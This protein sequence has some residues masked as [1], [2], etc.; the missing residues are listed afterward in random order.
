MIMLIA[1]ICLLIVCLITGTFYSIYTY[2][3]DVKNI[4]VKLSAILSCAV[5]AIVTANLT[6][7]VGG[8]SIFAVIGFMFLLCA[9]CIS[10]LNLKENTGYYYLKNITLSLG[11]V[12]FYIAGL[13]FGIFNAFTLLFGIFVAI[14]LN[15]LNLAFK[16]H[17]KT[18]HQLIAQGVLL[19]SI[20]LFLSQGITLVLSSTYLLIGLFY[21][22][23]SIFSIIGLNIH[24][25]RKKENNLLRIA[26]NIV[27]ILGLITF[28]SSIYFI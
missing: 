16:R 9:E 18:K 23:G 21:L 6:S 20:S 12:C 27:Y 8:Y 7:A 15:C 25:L 4:A 3:T 24:L 2:K 11:F 10:L 13:T 1:F 28:A 17:E 22:F 26:G 5:L 19:G 14:A